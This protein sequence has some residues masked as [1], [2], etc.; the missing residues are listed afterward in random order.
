[1]L[2]L[3]AARQR[4]RSREGRCEGRKPYGFHPNEQAIIEHMKQ[5]RWKPVKDVALSFEGIARQLNDEGH[6]TRY[7]K[8]W[9]R[10]AVHMV[11]SRH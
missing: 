9:T 8:P 11:L 10:A 3:R 4:I 2:K 7:G 5:L 6:T 1:V